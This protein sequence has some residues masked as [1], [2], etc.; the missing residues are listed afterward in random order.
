MIYEKIERKKIYF[1]N[2]KKHILKT[3]TYSL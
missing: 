3:M 1:K 2:I